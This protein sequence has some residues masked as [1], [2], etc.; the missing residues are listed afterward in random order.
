MSFEE[1]LK[2]VSLLA[3][4]SLA[5]YTGVPGL[6]GSAEPND[7]EAL[8]RI[9]RVTAK[10]TV[11]ITTA[12]TQLSIGVCQ[13]KP[14]VTGQACTVAIRGISNVVAG[15]N[16]LTAGAEVTSDSTGRAVIATTG[17]VVIGVVLEAS[18]TVGQLVPLLIRPGVKA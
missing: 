11:G 10:H 8:F 9:V 6:P 12:D 1:T 16:N 15:V 3:D 13:S 2:S 4:A 14:Q 17:D 18:T 7:G 5:G